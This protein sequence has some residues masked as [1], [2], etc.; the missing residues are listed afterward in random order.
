M[1]QRV[2]T[3]LKNWTLLI[4]ML[5][6]AL[7]YIVYTSIPS[8]D[9]THQQALAIVSVLQPLLLFIMLFLT[10]CKV[11][12]HDLHLSPWQGWLLLLQCSTFAA[13]ALLLHFFPNTHLGIVVEGGM[14]CMICPTASAAAVVTRKLGGN[15]G[16]L[17]AYTI[18]INLSA[19]ML[20]P[21]LVPLIHP[22][23]DQSFFQSFLLIIY[24]VFPLLLG[25]FFLSI[26]LRRYFPRLTEWLAS[27]RDL[28]FYLWA[29]GLSLAIAMTV[30]NIAHTTL[31][32]VYQFGIALVS[33]LACALQFYAG[34]RMGLK[35][36]DPISAAQACGQKN[37]IFAI[38]M[39]YTFM[40]PITSIAGGFYSVWHNLWNT[41]QL[42]RIKGNKG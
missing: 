42:H 38:W 28:P 17:M 9:S 29:V 34:R 27:H 18:I 4:S 14:I 40:T 30:R 3:F 31:P 10:F 24:R 20:V 36:D 5:T 15:A 12:P 13:G 8:L 41:Y 39:G 33:L 19:A 22:H 7:G 32:P 23:P 21:A 2:I 1:I 26:V 6:G 11:K 37:T 25:P 16:T 35:Y